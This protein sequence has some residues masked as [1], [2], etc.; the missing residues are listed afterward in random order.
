MSSLT[1]G[2]VLSTF[3]DVYYFVKFDKSYIYEVSKYSSF[4]DVP[5]FLVSISSDSHATIRHLKDF[6]ACQSEGHKVT[7]TS[8]F[9]NTLVL[10]LCQI[11]I[12]YC[13]AV[14]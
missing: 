13:K 9:L 1:A 4:S 6:E 12:L 8:I 10:V 7:K 5:L 14:S 11:H 3:V 2:R